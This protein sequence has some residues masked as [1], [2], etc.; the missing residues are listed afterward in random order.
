MHCSGNGKGNVRFG[1]EADIAHSPADVCFT[2]RSGHGPHPISAGRRDAAER[3][4]RCTSLLPP[5]KSHPATHMGLS[6]CE[7]VQQNCRLLDQ[8]ISKRQVRCW[9]G[10]TECLSAVVRLMTNSNLVDCS[11]GKSRGFSPF[12][13]RPTYASQ[14][15]RRAQHAEDLFELRAHRQ[16]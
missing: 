16:V 13:I 2:R 8:L 9:D 4:S 12:R 10:Q 1:S 5:Q 11:T 6:S 14:L 15:I 3:K 7:Q